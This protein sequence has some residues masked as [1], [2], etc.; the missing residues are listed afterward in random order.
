MIL[1]WRNEP[2]TIPW[3]GAQR[4]L[5]QAEHESWFEKT[6]NDPNSLTLIIE[7][8]SEPVGKIGYTK[9]GDVDEGTAKVTINLTYRAQGKGIAT[10]AFREGSKL[11]RDL[12]FADRIIARVRLDNIGSIK[13]LE[14]AGFVGKGTVVAHGEEHALLVDEREH[15]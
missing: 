15:A 10:V 1:E 12:K 8:D 13:A 14:N 2:T 5:T 7:H 11:V 6:L 4:P 3:M 9:G